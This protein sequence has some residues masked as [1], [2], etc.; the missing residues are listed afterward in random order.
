MS[1][2]SRILADLNAQIRLAKKLGLNDL[3]EELENRKWNL[4][5]FQ[6]KSHMTLRKSLLTGKVE[7]TPVHSF[8]IL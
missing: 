5:R 8:F 6:T 2:F 3:T 1:N 7:C 4:Y